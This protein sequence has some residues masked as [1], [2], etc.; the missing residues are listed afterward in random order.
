M[1]I[2]VYSCEVV[3]WVP[4]VSR[5]WEATAMQRW[6]ESIESP[7]VFSEAQNASKNYFIC[8]EER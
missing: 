5:Y 1:G 6:A 2:P 4:E 8:Q 3:T 7:L